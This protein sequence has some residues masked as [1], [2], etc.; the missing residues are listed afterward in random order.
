MTF[1]PLRRTLAGLGLVLGVLAL[2][3]GGAGAADNAIS[4][5]A[6]RPMI[7]V[8][9]S[10]VRSDTIIITFSGKIQAPLA[11]EIARA[12][13]SHKAT[14]KR[15]LLTINSG[16]GSVGEGKKVIAVLARIK[17]THQLDT[18]V[19]AGQHCGSMCVFLYAQGHKRYA[20]PASLWLF[21]EVSFTDNA[22]KQIT[23]LDRPK[24]IELIDTYLAPSGVSPA[25]IASL[26]QHAFGA[27]Y[28]RTGEALIRERSGLIHK[29]TSD[30]I[31]RTVVPKGGAQPAAM[32]Q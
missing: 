1:E 11:D 32:G 6:K 10:P 12:F 28:W 20:A 14:T 21:H 18:Y 8:K 2:S 7:A 9:P 19:K 25:W 31:K 26:K 23:R 27:D 24:W 4:L 16:G 13:D 5:P 29:A 17:A 3:G 15:V 30:E 22:T